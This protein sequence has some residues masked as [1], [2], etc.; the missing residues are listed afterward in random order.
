MEEIQAQSEMLATNY[1]AYAV[2]YERAREAYMS[3]VNFAPTVQHQ[4]N[5][6]EKWHNQFEVKRQEAMDDFEEMER[7]KTWYEYF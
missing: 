2:L 5:D 7:L 6:V 3:F 1:E 4:M